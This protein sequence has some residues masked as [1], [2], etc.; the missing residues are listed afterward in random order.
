[1]DTAINDN[2]AIRAAGGGV[3]KLEASEA[4]TAG[5]ALTYDANGKVQAWGSG[6]KVIGTALTAATSTNLFVT[7]LLYDR[8]ITVS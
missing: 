1:M 7:A 2:V 4:I 8:A 6:E 5:A 3:C